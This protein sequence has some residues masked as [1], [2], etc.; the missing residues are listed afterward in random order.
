MCGI[1][2][3]FGAGSEAV[4][5]RMST[6]IAHRGPDDSGASALRGPTGDSG[7]FVHRR[8][9]ILDLTD[10]A[11]QPMLSADGRYTLVFNGEIYNF[12][13]LRA[14]LEREGVIFRGTGDTE[15][16]LAGYTRHGARFLSRLRGMFAF[17]LWDRERGRGVLARDP[18]GIKPMYIA[19][20]DGRVHF[21]SEIRALLN[22][23]AAP[24]IIEREAVSGFLQYGSMP[25]P[26]SAVHGVRPLAPGTLVEVTVDERGAR[27]GASERFDSALH[28][29][30]EDRITDPARA[31]RVVRDALSDSVA[32]HLVSDVPV[33]VFLSGGIDSSAVV[34]LASQQ[35]STPLDSFTITFSEAAFDESEAARSV[36]RRYRTNHHEIPLT[37]GDLLAALGPAFDAMDQPS[38]D[39]LNTYAVSRAVRAAGLKVVLSGLGGDEL[40]AGYP[41]FSRARALRR[42]RLAWRVAA[43]LRRAAAAIAA[44]AGG[45]RGEKAALMLRGAT[46]ELG[47]YDAS[48]G[49]F[50]GGFVRALGGRP[51]DPIERPPRG[52]SGAAASSWYELTGYM[53][54]TLLRDSDVFSM[55]HCLELRVPFVD[56]EVAAAAM[57]IDDSLLLAPGAKPVLVRAVEDLIPREVWDRPKQGFALPFA[58]WM[59][60]ELRDEVAAA[61]ERPAGAERVGLRASAVRDVW[62]GFLAGRPGITWSRAWALF[63]LI[64]W[65]ELQDVYVASGDASS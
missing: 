65:A 28:A 46:P 35:S 27:L 19:E 32:A 16:L 49:L 38:M 64:R 14:E 13:A 31:A 33:A 30:A 17:G 48:R 7:C 26:W 52:W 56:K 43:P 55:A 24:R 12:R 20:H 22:S 3:V 57:S 6:C 45:M 50:A 29:P 53:R 37:G 60:N 54:N 10:A 23:G 11:H 34:A 36:A 41:S 9:S 47:A 39:G 18:F 40:F 58:S 21:A 8:L 5:A 42:A 1:A 62:T 25:E 61:L 63:T 59:R 15:V 4:A 51:I 44:G 2:G